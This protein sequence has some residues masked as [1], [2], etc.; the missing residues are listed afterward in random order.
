M[1]GNQIGSTNVAIGKARSAAQFRRPTMAFQQGLAERRCR[2]ASLSW[3]ARLS[4]GGGQPIVVDGKMV[5]GNRSSG[6]TA[7]AG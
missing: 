1:D 3:K 2:P 4:V 7:D 6:G 5:G